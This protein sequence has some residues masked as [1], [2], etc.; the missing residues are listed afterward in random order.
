MKTCLPL[1]SPGRTPPSD[2]VVRIDCHNFVGNLEFAFV[3][4]ALRVSRSNAGKSRSRWARAQERRMGAILSGWNQ[5]PS[6]SNYK[7]GG[8]GFG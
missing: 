7:S 6:H 5:N 4:A 3:F 1:Y 8:Y 2:R